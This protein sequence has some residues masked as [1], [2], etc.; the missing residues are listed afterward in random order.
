MKFKIFSLIL[1]ISFCLI[2]LIILIFNT[3]IKIHAI[4][5]LYVNNKETILV[6]NNDK[7][8]NDIKTF[9]YFILIDKNTKNNMKFYPKKN[10]F[11]NNENLILLQYN[12]EYEHK[13]GWYEVLLFIKSETIAKHYLG[14]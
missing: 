3:Q 10:S 9:N 7:I 2:T 13:N 11:I 5:Q 4:C 12:P 1:L 8:I 6:L 14:F